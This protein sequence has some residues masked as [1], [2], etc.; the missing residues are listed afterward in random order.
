MT[1]NAMISGASATTG[2]YF[3]LSYAHSDPLVGYPDPNPDK[4]VTKF[5]DDLSEAV[6]RHA[7]RL[8]DIAPGFYDRDIPVGSNWNESIR[9]VLSTVQAFVPLYSVAYIDRSWPGQ[10]WEC[11]R[12][13]LDAAGLA[14][15]LERFVPVLW[16]PLPPKAQ[17]QPGLRA[18]LDLGQGVDE[19]TENGLRQLLRIDSYRPSYDHILGLVT[20]KIVELA[21][22]NPIERSATQDPD[23]MDNPFVPK[24]HRT[25]F[26][27]ETIAPTDRTVVAERN[28]HGYGQRGSDWRPFPEQKVPLAHYAGQVAKQLG[29]KAEF[30]EVGTVKKVKNLNT[31]GPGIILID[32]WFIAN[33]SGRL[34]LESAVKNLPS[35][36]LPMIILDQ[37]DD[38][39]TQKLADQVRE[40]L[41]AVGALHTD[42]SRRIARGIISLKDFVANVNVLVADAERQFL[43]HPTGRQESGQVTSTLSDIRPRLRRAASRG[44]QALVSDQPDSGPGSLEGMPDD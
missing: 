43:R 29:F 40:I 34:A 9:Q 13:R 10:E 25:V 7:V 28:R 30:A 19:Y 35:W 14:D 27:I 33:E 38:A 8:P 2:P 26:V 1:E 37:P 36:V 31:R 5:F 32:P 18:A 23:E 20:Q 41:N 44:G 21:E 12:Q 16:T 15:P 11:F 24:P 3:F 39:T 6:R 17:D 4:L 42:S 22:T